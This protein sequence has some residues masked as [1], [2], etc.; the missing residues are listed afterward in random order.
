MINK[1]KIN[2]YFLLSILLFLVSQQEIYTSNKL[3]NQEEE[4]TPKILSWTKEKFNKAHKIELLANKQYFHLLKKE[5]IDHINIKILNKVDEEK[6]CLFSYDQFSPMQLGN[7]KPTLMKMLRNIHTLGQEQIESLSKEHIS[8]LGERI[9]ELTKTQ[10]SFFQKNQLNGLVASQ[11]NI[12]PVDFFST[13]QLKKMSPEKKINF[14]LY[15]NLILLEAEQLQCLPMSSLGND[16]QLLHPKQLEYLTKT[17][18]ELM[19]EKQIALLKDK[20]YYLTEKQIKYLTKTQIELMNEEQI[21]LLK[22]KI[23]YLTEK[24]IKLFS[25]K[26]IQSLSETQIDVCKYFDQRQI[27]SLSRDQISMLKPNNIEDINFDS[28]NSISLNLSLLEKR[29]LLTILKNNIIL[30]K[31][32]WKSFQPLF[33]DQYPQTIDQ[34]INHKKHLD[35]INTP[36][37]ERKGKVFNPTLSKNN[38]TEI[39]SMIYFITDL[40]NYEE[41]GLIPLLLNKA[42]SAG[43]KIEFFLLLLPDTHLRLL[44]RESLEKLPYDYINQKLFTYYPSKIIFLAP[45]LEYFNKKLKNFLISLLDIQEIEK[46]FSLYNKSE[47]NYDISTKL[48]VKKKK[49]IQESSLIAL[50]FL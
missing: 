39:I 13:N 40:F 36:S 31:F 47:L 15:E 45:N 21:A 49:M 19:N 41:G 37:Q 4:N 30:N 23:Y 50:F 2:K 8:E 16:I 26:Q 48:A 18:I 42:I 22:D 3:P 27:E 20:I 43:E 25:R 34:I 12:L 29:A 33:N 7:L 5:Q 10:L 35:N 28:M 24:Q 44:P 46:I 32:N 11:I 1:K 6:I 9:K 38:Y 17:Q 14:K